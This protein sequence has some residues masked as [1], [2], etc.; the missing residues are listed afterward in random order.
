MRQIMLE[1]DDL[2]VLSRAMGVAAEKIR[3][4]Q[5]AFVNSFDNIQG[6]TD[7][8]IP[9][10]SRLAKEPEQKGRFCLCRK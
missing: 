9:L 2:E 10:S 7:E 5:L 4:A 6:S 1:Q 3:D 8:Y